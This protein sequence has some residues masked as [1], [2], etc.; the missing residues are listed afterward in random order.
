[1]SLLLLE[2]LAGPRAATRILLLCVGI[3]VAPALLLGAWLCGTLAW[4]WGSRTWDDALQRASRVAQGPAPATDVQTKVAHLRRAQPT[5]D[6]PRAGLPDLSAR[7]GQAI[8]DV[9]TVRRYGQDGPARDACLRI[10][11]DFGRP[12]PEGTLLA[13][14][15]AC[16]PLALRV[17]AG[18]TQERTL[19][20]VLYGPLPTAAHPSGLTPDELSR[21]YFPAGK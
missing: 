5:G 18:S 2:R 15:A 11:V 10:P 7:R 8:D 3:T 17:R 13:L 21:R 1:L 6:A 9:R 14:E 16:H 19:A 12:L 20:E 4:Q